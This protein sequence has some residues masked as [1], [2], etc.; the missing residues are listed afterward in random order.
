MIC[1]SILIAVLGTGCGAMKRMAI[2]QVGDALAEGNS[3]FA[4]DED[5]ELVGEA[6]PFGLK[7]M[8]SLLSHTPDH[9]GMLVAACQGFTSYSYA[10]VNFD[11]EVTKVEADLQE[12]RAMEARARRLYLRAHEYGLRALEEGYEGISRELK[13]DPRAAVARV[14]T[15][16]VPLLYWSAASLGLA[17]S[18]SRGDAHML[19]RLPE[20]EALLRRALELDETWEQGS[21]HEFAIVLAGAGTSFDLEAVPRL[22]EHYDRA[23][24]LSEGARASLFV[25]WA[26]SV[27]VP[28]QDSAEFRAMLQRALEIDPDEHEPIRLMNLV[29]QRRA[30]WLL[31]RMDDLF[32]D[33]GGPGSVEEEG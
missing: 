8:E 19:V 10:Y 22:R 17:I 1:A 12:G 25:T 27:S 9:Q 28:S 6:L 33:P 3:V 30:R 24:E 32:L 4:T 23:L 7:L 11:A 2:G 31:G 29:S 18:V 13:L 20:V 14:K 15:E 21:L 26:E 5:L 16:D